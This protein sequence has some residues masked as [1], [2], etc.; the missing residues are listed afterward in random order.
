MTLTSVPGLRV[1]HAEVPG[2]GSG[3]TVILGPFRG[4]ADIRGMATGSREMDP[5]A[6]RHL[7]PAIDALV[8]TGG[9]AFGLASADG[10]MSWLEERGAGFE[11]G[12]ARV[13]IVPA[14]VIFDLSPGVARP[15]AAL[16]R[17]SCEA[18][19]SGPV[20]SGRVGAG[21]GATAGKWRGREWASPGGVGSAALSF[22]DYAV[23]AL[24]VVNPLGDVLDGA[25]GILAGARGPEGEFLNM[26]KLLLDVGVQ[27]GFDDA[28]F[29]GPGENTTL[30]VVATDAPLSQVN[31]DRLARMASTGVARRIS[32]VNTPYDGDVTFALSTAE[33]VEEVSSGEILALGATAADVVES[34]IESAVLGVRGDAPPD[35]GKG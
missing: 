33:S 14:A 24:A 5:F 23:G 27:G 2:G 20:A 8:L 17:A 29:P 22:G 12:V 28:R 32:P 19:H 3:C 34:A 30:V 6:P 18:A 1:G 16:G 13:P 10:V 4:A 35:A 21:A 31:L 25:G 7:V 11:T 26:A 9:S 15:D